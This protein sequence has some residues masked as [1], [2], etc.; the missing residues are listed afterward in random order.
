MNKNRKIYYLWKWSEN[1][2]IIFPNLVYNGLINRK[3]KLYKNERTALGLLFF[4]EKNYAICSMGKYETKVCWKMFSNF[5][6]NTRE[7]HTSRFIRIYPIIYTYR[8][9]PSKMRIFFILTKNL[10]GHKLWNVSNLTAPY[11]TS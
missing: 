11:F 6:F 1:H 3:R 8:S 7:P 9:R 2:G 4:S 10:I 5:T